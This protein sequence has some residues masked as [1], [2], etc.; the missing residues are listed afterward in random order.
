[1][2]ASCCWVWLT[3]LTRRQHRVRDVLRE[4]GHQRVPKQRLRFQARVVT[5]VR[6]RSEH[7]KPEHWQAPSLELDLD[8]RQIIALVM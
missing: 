7:K 4:I 1:M 3:N 5:R 2:R 8:L 6:S